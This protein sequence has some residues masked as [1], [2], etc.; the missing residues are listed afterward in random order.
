MS[1]NVGHCLPIQRLWIRVKLIYHHYDFPVVYKA[2][3]EYTDWYRR[4]IYAWTTIYINQL[5]S[6]PEMTNGELFVWKHKYLKNLGKIDMINPPIF[7][8]LA[9]NSLSKNKI[10]KTHSLFIGTC[11]WQELKRYIPL[12]GGHDENFNRNLGKNPPF[13]L[14]STR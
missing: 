9:N 8:P 10:L 14:P 6:E 11:I 13:I 5:V 7:T 12:Y 4:P 1:H 3:L 2:N